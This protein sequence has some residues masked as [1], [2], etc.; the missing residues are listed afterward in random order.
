MNDQSLMPCL[1]VA[2]YTYGPL[3]GLFSFGVLTT[4]QVKDKL[5]PFVCVISPVLS[6]IL[7]LNS[8]VWLG[9]YV[10]G[11]EILIVNGI[12]TFGGLWLVSRKSTVQ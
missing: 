6:Y 4:R 10:F 2:G 11:I 12:I 1:N 3:L 5:V 7:S 9:G 8:K